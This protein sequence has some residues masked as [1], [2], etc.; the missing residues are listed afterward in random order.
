MT[1]LQC[2]QNEMWSSL[3]FIHQA[4]LVAQMVK[5]LPAMRE[6]QVQTLGWEDPL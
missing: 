3:Y 1:R 2:G 4:S 5:Y 6:T